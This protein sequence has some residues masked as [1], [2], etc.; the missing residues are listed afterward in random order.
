[1]GL[2][3]TLCLV[4]MDTVDG[5]KAPRGADKR[6]DLGSASPNGSPGLPGPTTTPSPGVVPSREGSKTASVADSTG[7]ETEMQGE[8]LI[9]N[10]VYI[11]FYVYNSTTLCIQTNLLCFFSMFDV[12]LQISLG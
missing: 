10:N 7:Q 11:Y 4:K 8:S 12:V 3:Q 1:M 9:S 5:R 2:L 6:A